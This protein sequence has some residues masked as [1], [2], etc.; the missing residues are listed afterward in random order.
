MTTYL[1]PCDC[2]ADVA[3]TA[4][5]AGGRVTCRQCG[6]ELAVPKF[7]DLA[8]LRRQEAVVRPGA[9]LWRPAKAVVFLGAIVCAAALLVALWLA[10]RATSALDE[11]ALRAAVLSVDDLTVY[12]VW[13]EGL[14]RERVRR[15]PA[16]EELALLRQTRF[17]DGLR[18]VLHIVAACGALAALAAG[19]RLVL[20]SLPS[21]SGGHSGTTAPNVGGRR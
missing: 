17:A 9:R 12:R 18:G 7:G 1:L 6:R 11:R 13:S 10:P 3:V 15:P 19:L 2:A 16:D 4:G 5:Q 21:G 20:S 8:R 14:S